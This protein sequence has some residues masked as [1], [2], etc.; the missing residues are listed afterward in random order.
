M[1]R[2]RKDEFCCGA[3]AFLAHSGVVSPA[4]VEEPLRKD[5]LQGKLTRVNP[6]LLVWSLMQ[7]D[8]MD[9]QQGRQIRA[10][11]VEARRAAKLTQSEVARDLGVSRQTVSHWENGET[12][13]SWTDLA[14]LCAI[15]GVSSDQILYGLETV[16][17]SVRGSGF[18][19]LAAKMAGV[20]QRP[21]AR[22]RQGGLQEM[23]AAPSGFGV[24]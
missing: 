11:M 22:P 10:R 16:S 20:T 18:A 12:E 8:W 3:Q 15:Y 7:S 9:T 23:D 14:R 1:H 24:L 4:N 13:A 21:A 2:R 6:A 19:W 17:F 5:S